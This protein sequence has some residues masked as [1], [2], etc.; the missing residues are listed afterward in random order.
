[1]TDIVIFKLD[2]EGIF[3]RI[4]QQNVF[5]TISSETLPRIAVD[6]LGDVYV[7]YVTDGVV[8]GGSH[9]GAKDVILMKLNANLDIQMIIQDSTVNTPGGTNNDNPV[10]ATDLYGGV[11]VAYFTT[12]TVSGGTPTGMDDIVLFKYGPTQPP[13][14]NHGTMILCGVD[15]QEKYVTIQDIHPGMMVKTYRHGFRRVELIGHG[16]MIN[17]PTNWKKC[18]YRM[19]KTGLMLDDLVVTGGHSIL[20]KT[21]VTSPEEQKKQALVWEAHDYLIDDQY[22]ILASISSLFEKIKDTNKYTYYHIVLE[23]EGNDCVQYGIW[24]N[25][26]LTESQSR[27]KFVESQYDA[28]D[29]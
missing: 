21:P 14:F 17:D 12:G 20:S 2:T 9:V 4:I 3:Q 29:G 28:V 18:M 11:Y 10:I 15:G 8:S 6:Y 5:N 22:M 26:V 7:T 27:D 1:M 13:C 24:A 23:N 25:G 16:E 19:C